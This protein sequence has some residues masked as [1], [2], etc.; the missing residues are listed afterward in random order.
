MC[1]NA[2]FHTDDTESVLLQVYWNTVINHFSFTYLIIEY[3]FG[4]DPQ[5][6]S[7]PSIHQG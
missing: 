3:E 7:P 1:F 2:I 5:A 6:Q 4:V